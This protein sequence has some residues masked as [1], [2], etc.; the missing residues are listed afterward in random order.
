MKTDSIR[1]NIQAAMCL[2][3]TMTVVIICSCI[4]AYRGF[5]AFTSK[6]IVIVNIAMAVALLVTAGIRKV[7]DYVHGVVFTVACEITLILIQLVMD[8]YIYVHFGIILY[9]IAL[10]IYEMYELYDIA[11]ISS[12]FTYVLFISLRVALAASP[13]SGMGIFIISALGVMAAQYVIRLMVRKLNRYKKMIKENSLSSQD[14]LR[15]VELKRIEAKNAMKAKSVFLSNMSHEIKTPINAILGSDELIMR[16][17]SDEKVKGYAANIRDAGNTLLSMLDDVLELSQIENGRVKLV[18]AEYDVMEDMCDLYEVSGFMVR[19]KGMELDFSV[20]PDMPSKLTGDII[21]IRQV[22]LYVLSKVISYSEGG[23]IRIAIDWQP[24][25]IRT[26]KLTAAVSNVG[27]KIIEE[28]FDK[29]I[30]IYN[31][32]GSE[33]ENVSSGLGMSIAKGLCALMN[34]GIRMENTTGVGTT[35]YVDIRQ[36]VSD[37]TAVGEFNYNQR[38]T[39]A[40]KGGDILTAPDA[41]ILVVDDNEVNLE[42]IK[43]L[44]KSTKS[45]VNTAMSGSECMEAVRKEKYDIIFL[46]YMMP[47]LDG[48]GTLKALRA[49]KDNLSLDAPVI[50]LTANTIEAARDKYI[51][52]GFDGC[53]FKPVSG[54]RLTDTLAKFL[55]DELVHFEPA[56]DGKNFQ[57]QYKEDGIINIR[58]GMKYAGGD[59]EQF[60]STVGLFV[61]SSDE[62]RQR[63]QKFMSESDLK[64]YTIQIHALKSSARYIGADSLADAAYRHECWGNEENSRNIADDWNNL[65]KIWDEVLAAA[66]KY[67]PKVHDRTVQSEGTEINSEEIKNTIT[68]ITGCIKEFDADGAER[69]IDMLLKC[70]IS[71]AQRDELNRTKALLNNFEYKE[72]LDVLSSCGDD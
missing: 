64:N 27:G 25:G 1:K 32:S 11:A 60:R 48:I 42:V 8:S 65:L 22:S 44:L 38:G 12:M 71:G 37:Y 17:C 5:E 6:L 34:G 58:H 43:G 21:R 10:C 68:K 36:T 39:L 26:V 28:E 7:T 45:F 20:A 51:R 29:F 35:V 33:T 13:V 15:V 41:K 19:E 59:E 67:M 72:A 46:D 47:E 54:A 3:Y 53:L 57:E 61:S 31:N 66:K 69:F 40:A 9:S 62:K 50:V 18:N 4:Y 49:M 63:L 56:P 16:E 55:P 52:T 23:K 30:N 14:M 24:D 2:V 70:E